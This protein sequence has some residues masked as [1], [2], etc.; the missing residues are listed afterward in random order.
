MNSIYFMCNKCCHCSCAEKTVDYECPK[1]K[2]YIELCYG[3]DTCECAGIYGT[4][5]Y[6]TEC[7]WSLSKDEKEEY[8]NSNKDII[9][10]KINEIQSILVNLNFELDK[11]KSSKE[12]I[13]KIKK[14]INFFIDK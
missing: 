10:D 11:S 3:E 9:D 13:K 7:D 6:C 1:C 12:L 5:I 2:H 8:V 14:E 4:D